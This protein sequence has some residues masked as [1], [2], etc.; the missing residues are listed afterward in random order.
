MNILTLFSRLIVGSLFIVSGLIK[1]NDPTGFSYKLEEYFS[2]EVLNL[3]WLAPYALFMAIAICIVEIVLG[4]ATIM[5]SKIKL[6]SGLLLAMIVFFTFLT[7]YSAYF[8][9]V[10]DC[11]CFGDAIKL[12][13]WESFY[14]DVA[15]LILIVFLFIQKNKIQENT[16]K[17]DVILSFTS[18]LLIAGFSG[19]YIGWNFPIYFT[20]LLFVLI[21]LLKKM[22]FLPERSALIVISISLLFSSGF[23]FFVIRHL[24]IKD[25]RPYKVGTYI[26]DQIKDCNELQLP[27]PE[28]K[29]VYTLA[30]VDSDE[31][32][33]ISSDDY[34]AE[35]VWEDKSWEIRADETQSI[36]VNKG[37][38]PPIQDFVITRFDGEDV[39][40]MLL[41][42]SKFTFWVIAYD[43]NNQN[44]ISAADKIGKLTNE[45]DMLDYRVYGLT[46]STYEDTDA[47]RHQVQAMYDYFTADEKVLK[48][49]VRSNPGI[50]LVKQGIILGKWHY[51]DLPSMDWLKANFLITKG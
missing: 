25:F 45:S 42:D 27:C 43:I 10:T 24:P 38:E 31:T 8:E 26:P 16:L 32:K 14:K 44:N 36:L 20:L 41:T 12:T 17:L 30:K 22:S 50:I 28:Y 13:P 15:L 7:F 9:K 34:I 3:E 23:S 51:N 4:A 49:I 35:K 19:G 21:L 18:V 5:G 29:V 11:G 6:V 46:A 40:Q 2:P 48:T 37:Y 47:F 39:T 1:A 33:E